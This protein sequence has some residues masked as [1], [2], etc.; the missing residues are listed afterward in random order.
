[1]KK[2][3]KYLAIGFLVVLVIIQF[4]PAHLPANN[5]DLT[6]DMVL[7]ENIPDDVKLIL[8]KACYDCHSNQTVYPWYS[9]IAPVSWLVAKDTREGRDELNFSEWA[10]LKKRKKIKYLNGMA[11][12]VEEKKMP[13]KIYTVIHKDAILT[14]V[15][16]STLISWT[17]SQSEKIIAGE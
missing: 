8:E 9:R 10:D 11:E 13:M 17:K 15:E 1:M 4:V 3:L 5:S 2:A 16:I 6:N 14:D 7:T 12:E